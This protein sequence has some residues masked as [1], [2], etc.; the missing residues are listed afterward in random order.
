MKKTLLT[1]A[2]SVSLI[3]PNFAFAQE[4]VNHNVSVEITQPQVELSAVFANNNTTELQVATLSETEMKKRK[5]LGLT[6]FMV[7]WQV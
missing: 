3:L 6:S 2:C 7:D 4:Q 5:G 1:I